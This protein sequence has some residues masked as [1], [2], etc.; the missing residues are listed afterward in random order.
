MNTTSRRI[1]HLDMYTFYA[2]VELLRYPELIGLPVVI[3]GR[4]ERMPMRQTDSTKHFHRLREYTG[5]GVI[6]TAI[7]EAH[8]LGV[9]SGMGVMKVAQLA[10]D[11]ILLSVDFAAAILIGCMRWHMVLMHALSLCI[12]NLNQSAE[13]PPLNTISIHAMIAKF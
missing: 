13:K 2:S 4:A 7:Y 3:G 8:G 11:E 5:R 12:P 9:H 10:P 6:T 1:A